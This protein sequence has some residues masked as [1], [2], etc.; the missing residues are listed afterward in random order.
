MEKKDIYLDKKVKNKRVV[1]LFSV[2]IIS[3]LFFVFGWSV[4]SDRINVSLL[5]QNRI[6][7]ENASLPS[8]LDYESV[9]DVYDILRQNYDG[10]LKLDDVMNGLKNG[11]ASSTGDPYTEYLSEKEANDFDSELNG[12]FSGIGAELSKENDL[13]VVVSPISGYPADK[14]GLR[15]KDAI[16]EIDGEKTYN[17]TLTEAVEKIRGQ[18]GSQVELTVLRAESDKQVIKIKRENITIPSVEWSVKK[19]NVGYIKISRFAD[20]TADL[21]K[22]AALDL[23]SKGVKS[24]VLDLRGNPG[25]LLDSAVDISSLWLDKNQIVV[26]EKRDKVIIKTH[27][28]SGDNILTGLPTI[29]L[30]DEG[31]ASASEIVAGALKDNNKADLAGEESYGKGSVQQLTP[32]SSGGLLKITIARWYTP[33]GRNIDK[34]GI[35]PDKKVARTLKDVKAGKD[36]QLD[37]AVTRLKK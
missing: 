8:S 36:P 14:A 23:K 26:E 32:I 29:V 3:T 7:T 5:N 9:N 13:L 22:K 12:T 19:G 2:F 20:D 34:E 28:A 16:L 37:Y 33:N 4:G 31:S 24:V 30:I 1:S 21:A 18:S 11:L 35:A 27:K 17:M 6:Q 25:G 15:P 10:E